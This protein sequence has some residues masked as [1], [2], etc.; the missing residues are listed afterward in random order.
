VC[1]AFLP[2]LVEHGVRTTTG[3]S[4]VLDGGKCLSVAVREVFGERT[5]NQRLRWHERQNV[6]SYSPKTQHALWHRQPQAAYATSSFGEAKRA[7]RQFVTKVELHNASAAR[8]PE[9]GF[10]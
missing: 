4:V 6:L 5:P 2:E 9:E 7:L 10:E 3:V 8:S 1:A